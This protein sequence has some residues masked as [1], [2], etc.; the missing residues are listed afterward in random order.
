M[1]NELLIGESLES[2]DMAGTTPEQRLS[3]LEAKAEN[4]KEQL[5]KLETNAGELSKAVIEIR[6]DLKWH[7]FIGW[8]IA[9]VYAAIFTWFLNSYLPDKFNDR[10]PAN[11]KEEWGSLKQNITVIQDR[12]NRLTPA[13]LNDLIPP[14]TGSTKAKTVATQLRKASQVIDVAL[15]SQ[16]P[17]DPDLL[18]PLRW[19][20]AD[21]AQRYKNDSEVR[22]AASATEVRLEGY[23][24]ASRKLLEGLKPQTV[25]PS[26]TETS[27]G[28]RSYF[29]DFTMVCKYPEAYFIKA[30]SLARAETAAIVDVTVVACQQ[31]L[32]G[33]KW[34]NVQFKN[35]TVSYHGGPLYL[36]DVTFQN[37]HFDFGND[38]ESQEVLS[39]IIARHGKPVSLLV[40]P[41]GQRAPR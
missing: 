7:R 37:S 31:K 11:F 20:V 36:A 33:F 18:S 21:I 12:L 27:I 19:R 39:A 40:E 35:N 26:D 41:Q 10:L 17:G 32:E 16:I 23:V 8:G 29:M 2:L 30:E 25:A 28:L 4:T 6:N 9:A 22:L 38:V 34:L 15:K 24:I 14:P 13:T 3:S 5:S 1:Q